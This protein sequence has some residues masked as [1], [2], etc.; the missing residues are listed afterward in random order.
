MDSGGE[1]CPHPALLG[2]ARP[3][4]WGQGGVLLTCHPGSGWLPEGPAERGRALVLGGLAGSRCGPGHEVDVPPPA[5]AAPEGFGSSSVCLNCIPVIVT[6]ERS[7]GWGHSEPQPLRGHRSRYGQETS[8]GNLSALTVE[9]D[10]PPDGPR[11]AAGATAGKRAVAGSL[12]LP[13]PRL[14]GWGCLRG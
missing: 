13:I 8:R 11:W 12:D 7:L 4:G 9:A 10:A 5:L 2:Q 3:G 6:T 1:P 14:A